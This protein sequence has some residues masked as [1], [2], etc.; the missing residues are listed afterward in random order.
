VAVGRWQ[1]SGFRRVV[2]KVFAGNVVNQYGASVYFSWL[3]L[4]GHVL[5]IFF[6]KHDFRGSCFLDEHF[7]IF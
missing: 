5:P 4:S 6:V 1:G 3:T 7:G 2:I